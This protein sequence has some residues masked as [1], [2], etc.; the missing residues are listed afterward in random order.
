MLLAL[1][2]PVYNERHLFPQVIERIDQTPPPPGINRLLCIVDD[3]STDGTAALVQHLGTRPDVRIVIHTANR[4]K[5]AAL[6]TG[7]TLAIENNADLILV[8]DADLEYD[9]EDHAAV[10][11]PLIDGKADAVIGS[12]F[13]GQTHRVLYY[14]HSIANRVITTFSNMCTNLNLTDIECGT[15]AFNKDIL[16]KIRIDESDFAVEPEL[17]A[18]L[19]RLRIRDESLKDTPSQGWRRL[20]IYEVPVSYWGRTYDEGK[21]IRPKDGF[22]ALAAIVRHNLL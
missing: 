8:Q 19:S 20:R 7:F 1:V 12:R 11:A 15:K 4:G 9:P 3:G 2:I 5:G 22:R 17:I 16:N 14:W 10:L 21:K 13:L 18:K 6:R